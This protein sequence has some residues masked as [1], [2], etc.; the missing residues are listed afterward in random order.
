M[1]SMNIQTATVD[2]VLSAGRACRPAYHTRK[3][4][5][6]MFASPCDWM[7]SYTLSDWIHILESEAADMMQHA[8][9]APQKKW[10]IDENNGM[11]CMHHFNCSEPLNKQLPSF[12]KKNE[13]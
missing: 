13:E 1:H 5:M 12:S 2:F 11:V 9:I 10:V 7:M 3:L 6:R 8:H 4:G